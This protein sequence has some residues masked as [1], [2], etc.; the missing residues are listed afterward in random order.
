MMSP[1]LVRAQAD[2]GE[3]LVVKS[4]VEANSAFR[5]ACGLRLYGPKSMLLPEMDRHVSDV[6]AHDGRR[7]EYSLAFGP[8]PEAGHGLLVVRPDSSSDEE[9][10]VSPHPLG[11]FADY[12][13]RSDE[14]KPYLQ[15]DGCALP[16]MIS[17]RSESDCETLIRDDVLGRG[18]IEE[19]R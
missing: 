4:T 9:V 16:L 2:V 18:L 3:R 5:C 15:L 8:D 13:E 12:D 14:W 6:D 10:V 17:F 19:P 7:P 11:W 1:P